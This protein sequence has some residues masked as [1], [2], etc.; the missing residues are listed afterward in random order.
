M[1]EHDLRALGDAPLGPEGRPRAVDDVLRRGRRLHRR[2]TAARAVPVVLAIAVL[3]GAGV[4]ALRGD[5]TSDPD[6]ST[7]P[8]E[9]GLPLRPEFCDPTEPEAV[10]AAEL[11]GLRLVPT[12]LPDGVEVG[13]ATPRRQA[14]GRC[15]EVDPALLLRATGGDGTVEA[16]I[17][18]E[19]PYREPYRGG[20]EVAL[21]PTQ[22]RG[23]AA[24]RLFNPT[25]PGSYS[26]FTWTERD[27]G[28]WILKGVGVD[29]PTLRDVAEGLALQ[30]APDDGEPVAALPDDAMPAGFAVA[31]QAP[32][33]P[34]VEGPSR[35]EWF[36]TTTP[37]WPEGCELT[38][39]TTARRAPPGRLYR[40]DSLASD[41][42]VRGREG[43]AVE[44][45]ESTF[46]EWQEA[47]GVVGSLHCPGD[48]DTAAQVADSLVE[49]GPDDPRITTSAPG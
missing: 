38:V 7:S 41:L 11:D 24:S 37:P 31:W 46:L 49:V 14:T 10:P 39:S 34:A 8:P 32:G 45:N 21:E 1:D 26:G 35:R 40:A 16:E 42:E 4:L 5:G 13:T 20:D 29:E 27:G 19:G 48:R 15:V 44:E 9:G 33:V 22:L 36:V 12:V 3:A 25:A 47:P 18:L 23:Q 28:S 6:V 2:A 30:S 17:T 43:F